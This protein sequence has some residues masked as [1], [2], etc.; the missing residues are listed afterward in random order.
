MFVHALFDDRHFRAIRAG[1][2]CAEAFPFMAAAGAENPRNADRDLFVYL[3]EVGYAYWFHHSDD[4]SRFEEATLLPDG[5]VR[6]TRT[7]EKLTLIGSESS[8][9]LPI[10]QATEPALY[11]TFLRTKSL[12]P[13]GDPKPREE[14]TA[15]AMLRVDFH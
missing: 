12:T 15:H 13:P 7:I 8:K 3:T 14:E 9:E 1:Q 11:L 2:P 4:E 6:A 10:T 5:R